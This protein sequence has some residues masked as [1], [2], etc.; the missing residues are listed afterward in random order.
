MKVSV[1]FVCLGNICRSPTAHGLFQYYIDQANLGSSILVD[2]AGTGS[3]HEGEPPD[4]RAQSVALNRGYDISH[5]RGRSVESNDFFN[6]DYMLA[7]DDQNLQ[8]LEKIKPAN[9]HCELG[10]F[11]KIANN[12]VSDCSMNNKIMQVPDPFYG[13]LAHFENAIALIDNGSKSLLAKIREKH[14]I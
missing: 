14:D 10:L 13:D 12:R 11:L 2:S 5:L 7:M 3:W 1:L 8:F 9:Y 4:S 6:F